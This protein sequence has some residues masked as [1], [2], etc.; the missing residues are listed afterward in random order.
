LS[1]EFDVIIVG[2][3][4]VGASLVH[5]LTGQG[6]RI[7]VIEATS[8]KTD[9]PPSFDDRSIALSHSS[10]N[11]L[12]SLGLW[13]ELEKWLEPIK[14]I[15]VSEK[16]QFGFARLDQSEEN[17]DALGYVVTAREFGRVLLSPLESF[18]DVTLFCPATLDSFSVLDDRIEVSIQ[19]DQPLNIS[20][21]LL[22]AADGGNSQVRQQLNIDVSEHFYKQYAVIANVETSKPHDNV[23]YERFT[24][25]G[26]VALLPMTDNRSA[27]VYTVREEDVDAVMAQ[28]DETFLAALQQRFGFRVGRFT[29]IGKRFSHELV[30]KEVAE[31]IRPR[32]ALIGNAAHTIHP[33][34]GQGFNLGIR[35]VAVLAEVILQQAAKGEDYGLLQSLQQYANWR[36]KDQREVLQA[37]DKLVRLF[38]NPLA[39]VRTGRNLGI[40]ALGV[41]PGARHWFSKHAMGMAGRQ[42]RLARGLRLGK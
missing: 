8:I 26:P 25:Q 33:V 35:D 40:L 38:T 4:M 9:M 5:A 34:A 14:K 22:I 28:D 3:G 15:H 23:A 37:T 29:R 21:K 19:A 20:G 27:L 24:E 2:G 11:I 36:H 32:I 42:T 18:D 16:G 1:T 12:R 30:F 41:L 10:A 17:V 6:L 39:V 7:A 13:S 31:H